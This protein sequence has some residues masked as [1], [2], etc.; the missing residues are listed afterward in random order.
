[1]CVNWFGYGLDLQ[2]FH[3]WDHGMFIKGVCVF[4]K[5]FLSIQLLFDWKCCL[6]FPPTRMSLTL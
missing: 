5:W 2:C 4:N 3:V 6:A 1:M